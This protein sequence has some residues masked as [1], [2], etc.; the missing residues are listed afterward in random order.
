MADFSDNYSNINTCDAI[1]GWTAT[2]NGSAVALNPESLEVEGTGCLE[3]V[4][5]ATG[6]STWYYDPAVGDDHPGRRS[7][8][9][10]ALVIY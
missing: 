3:L 8:E 2:G 6:L 10:R 9:Y 4:A 5:T 1:T 7:V